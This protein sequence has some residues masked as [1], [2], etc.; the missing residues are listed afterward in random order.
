MTPPPGAV[1]LA[2]VAGATGGLGA[3]IP[4]PWR[5]AAGAWSA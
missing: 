1:R 3:A 4:A 5:L 2:L